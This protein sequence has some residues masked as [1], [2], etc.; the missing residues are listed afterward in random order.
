MNQGS[1]KINRHFCDTKM[2]SQSYR[3]KFKDALQHQSFSINISLY[4]SK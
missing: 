3:K 2:R 1:V 4:I